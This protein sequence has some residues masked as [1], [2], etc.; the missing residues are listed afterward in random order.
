MVFI[1]KIQNDI[2]YAFRR[3]F[4]ISAQ[5]EIKKWKIIVMFIKSQK[6]FFISNCWKPGL[7]T[8]MQYYNEQLAHLNVIM[9]N[10]LIWI[11]YWKRIVIFSRKRTVDFATWQHLSSSRKCNAVSNQGIKC[12]STS[13]IFS[14]P[15]TFWLSLVF[16][17][18]TL[19]FW[20]VFQMISRY[21][22]ILQIIEL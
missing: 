19:L 22:K 1:M 8:T 17:H 12:S 3:V 13:G 21:Q 11:I 2:N 10:W 20:L 7:N 16:F 4:N 15:P 9:S 5:A 6:K 18:T 14:K